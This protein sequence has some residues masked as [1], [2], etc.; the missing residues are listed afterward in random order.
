MLSIT[1]QQIIDIFTAIKDAVEGAIPA[2]ANAIGSV[3]V[4]NF[5]ATQTVDGEVTLGAGTNAIGQ[6]TIPRKD[7]AVHESLT[8]DNTVGG[9]GFATHA[10]NIYALVTVETAQVRFT[11]DGTAPTTTI[12]HLANPGDTIYLDSNADIDAFRAIRTGSVSGVLKATFS[13]VA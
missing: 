2:G 13:G 12:G 11:V 3:D 5:P 8:V 1:R 7:A 6:V 9:V 4:D 10:A